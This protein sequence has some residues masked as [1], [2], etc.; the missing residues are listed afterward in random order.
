MLAGHFNFPVNTWPVVME[1]PEED[2]YPTRRVRPPGAGVDADLVAVHVPAPCVAQEEAEFAGA[3]IVIDV[4]ANPCR[5]SGWRGIRR[6]G[7]LGGRHFSPYSAGPRQERGDGN[8]CGPIARR[9]RRLPVGVPVAVV[10]GSFGSGLATGDAIG[11]VD[12]AVWAT[13]VG[14]IWVP[15]RPLVVAANPSTVVRTRISPI[16]ISVFFALRPFFA[17]PIVKVALYL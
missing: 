16:V 4:S 5:A 6:A 1:D 11:L 15:K 17:R 13:L 9:K 2:E 7:G 3:G 12:A 10:E 14:A 8:L